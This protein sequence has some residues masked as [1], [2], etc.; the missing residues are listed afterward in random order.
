MARK[1]LGNSLKTT[2]KKEEKI[3][4]YSF[5]RSGQNT[6]HKI[7]VFVFPC[8]IIINLPSFT[9][10][11][12]LVFMWKTSFQSDMA[13]HGEKG[14]AWKGPWGK[15]ESAAAK[16]IKLWFTRLCQ[17]VDPPHRAIVSTGSLDFNKITVGIPNLS[18]AHNFME[19]KSSVFSKVTPH[20]HMQNTSFLLNS[21][22]WDV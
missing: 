8:I 18:N 22:C 4:L 17:T 6:R 12:Q 16:S 11:A 10:G 7:V 20:T 9:S 21:P 19:P 14:N 13:K 1:H 15:E 3:S 5:R 2:K